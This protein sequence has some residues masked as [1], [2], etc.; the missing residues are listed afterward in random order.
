VVV[1][2]AM[3][4][5]RR[6]MTSAKDDG[7]CTTYFPQHIKLTLI[8]PYNAWLRAAFHTKLTKICQHILSKVFIR[9]A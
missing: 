9:R 6:S 4:K 2:H 5:Q 7:A 1:M 8:S 3:E